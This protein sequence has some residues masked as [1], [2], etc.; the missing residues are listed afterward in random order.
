MNEVD[1]YNLQSLALVS[2]ISLLIEESKHQVSR[3]AN[4]SLTLLF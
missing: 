3:V 4:S 2:E 1:K